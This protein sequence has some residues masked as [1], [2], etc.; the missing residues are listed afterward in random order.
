MLPVISQ[1]GGHP[2]FALI[3]ALML[4]F[5][6]PGMFPRTHTLSGTVTFVLLD[7]IPVGDT[8]QST[9]NFPAIRA[10]LPV[11]LRDGHQNVIATAKLSGG[12]VTNIGA[13]GT[14]TIS[15]C[16][17]SFRIDRIP[18]RDLYTIALGD[19]GQT[20]L[21]RAELDARNWQIEFAPW[22]AVE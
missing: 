12:I 5:P 19:N 1:E 8:C 6:G 18:R 20:M 10:G 11:V 9:D 22:G 3:A 16:Q 4:L 2:M 13:S 17:F 15:D 7:D 21:T 14:E